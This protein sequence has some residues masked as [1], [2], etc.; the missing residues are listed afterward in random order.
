MSL[1]GAR[2][3][4]DRYLMNTYKRPPL[5][6][7]RGKGCY[8]WDD[9]GK[10]YLDF[11]GGIAVNA[12]GHA[13]PRIVRVVRR[14]AARA[15]HVSNLFHNPY[16][17]P[18][19]E[20]LAKWS[21]LDRVFFTN[22]GTEAI[23]GALKL[24]RIYARKKTGADN[25]PVKTKILALEHSFHGRTFGALAVTAAAKYREPYEP[26]MPGAVFVRFND[27][28]DLEY[29]FDENVCAVILEPIQGEGG[30]FPV[31][32]AFYNRARALCTQHDAALI[33]DEIQ[34][35]LGRT[36][37]YFAYQ[38]FRALPD[39]AV[40]AKPLAGGLPLGAILAGEKFASAFSP[41]L[42]GTTFGGGPLIC[43]A[44]LEFLS[45]V[46]REKLLA[47]VRARGEQLRAGLEKLKS[48][49]D[50]VKE[51]RGEGLIVGVE[52]AI[53]GAAVAQEALKRGVI[54]NCTHERVL[55]FLPP[56]I[57]TSRQVKDFL[58]ALERVLSSAARKAK[59]APAQP[60]AAAAGSA[61]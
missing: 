51:V 41:G 33:A 55:R 2:R 47:N 9:R 3:A 36:G 34:C 16:Q 43:A 60:V 57:V 24:A 59:A 4:A 11:L 28:A 61:R 14:E 54:I 15:I 40:I 27:V 22:S 20:K 21:K 42:H 1:A 31:S 44:A 25:P 8:L 49:F 5:V 35:G 10:R 23:E 38:K 48:K 18:L 17:G 37:R 46:E 29:K 53:E 6:F 26:L 19:A 13:H 39:I 52:L 12:L 56:F 30:V 58:A 45:V 32:E 50:L 7:T